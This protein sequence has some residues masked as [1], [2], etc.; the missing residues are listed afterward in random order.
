MAGGLEGRL[1]REQLR[2]AR[3]QNAEMAMNM[4]R[5]TG[6]L[7]D[8]TLAQGLNRPELMLQMQQMQSAPDMMRVLGQYM[9]PSELA[10]DFLRK[11]GVQGEARELPQQNLGLAPDPQMEELKRKLEESIQRRMMEEQQ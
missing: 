9:D 3:M 8:L 7:E 10:L 1:Q 4:G 5:P 6:M 11:M 2:G